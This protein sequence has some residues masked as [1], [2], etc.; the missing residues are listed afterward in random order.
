MSDEEFIDDGAEVSDDEFIDDGAVSKDRDQLEGQQPKRWRGPDLE[1]IEVKTFSTVNEFKNSNI[2]KDITEN[3]S[4][5]KF[6]NI[7]NYKREIFYCKF[8]RKRKFK[9]CYKKVKISYSKASD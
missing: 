4:R 3:Y 1:W 5:R 7:Y 2:H 6:G 8:L 9:T